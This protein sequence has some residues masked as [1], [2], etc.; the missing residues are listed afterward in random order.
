MQNTLRLTVLAAALAGAFPALA[1][2]NA[3]VLNELKALR[4]RVAELEKKLEATKPK[5]GQ[6]GM[7]PEQARELNRVT[8]KTEALED[9]RDAQGL[10]NLTIS[11]YADPTYI[12]NQRQD[13]AGFQFLNNVA[14]DGYNYDNSYFG[15][16]AIDFQKETDSGTRYRLTLVPNRGTDSVIGNGGIVHEATISVP[17]TDLQTRFIAG[18]M[19]DWSGYEYL[20]PTL[21]KLI[22]HNLLFDFTLPTS[23]TGAGLDITSGKWWYRGMIGQLN[24]SKNPQNEKGQMIAYRVDYSRGEFQG[25]GFAGVH[26]KAPNFTENVV[27]SLTGEV[28]GQPNSRVDLF[29]FD[30]YFIRG[31]VTMQGQVS[32]GQQKKASVTPSAS[33]AL[34]DSRWWGVSALGAYKFDPRLEGIVRLD[35]INNK[36]N[37]GGLLG[38][39]GADDRNGIGPDPN[40]D[41]NKGANR[42]ALSLGLSYAFNLETTFKAEY[43][44]DRANLPVFLDVKSGNYRKTNNLFGTSV[45]VAF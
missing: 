42:T 19:P 39:T 30:A 27:D 16:I 41:P 13:R 22:T 5:D 18:H 12:F 36:K 43:R 20:Q 32:F 8:V 37:G 9:S 21:N 10:K 26:G 45:V 24:A 7:T 6:W 25:F 44:M 15:A 29:E 33:G 31:D 17:L 38:Y 14:D 2:S 35:Y 1:Q 34:R 28:I 40:G 3:D 23:Y 4:D 11:G